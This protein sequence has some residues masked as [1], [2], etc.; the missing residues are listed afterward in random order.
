MPTKVIHE[1][2]KFNRFYTSII[3]VAD[4]HILDSPYSLT[5][6][7]I[8][9]E[10]YHQPTINARQIKDIIKVDEGYLSRL[11]SKLVKLNLIVK[12]KSRLDQRISTLTLSENGE[13]IFLD[14]DNRSSKSIAKLIDHL[15]KN[16]QDEILVHF[17]KITE[18]LSKDD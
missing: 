9:F 14:L 6:A 2:R 10:I 7:R 4:N 1:I 5:E 11:I 8:L 18:L 15:S 13:R 17:E 16:Q 12:K 3:G